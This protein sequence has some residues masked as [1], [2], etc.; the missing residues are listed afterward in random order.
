MGT[1]SKHGSPVEERHEAC[2]VLGVV[3]RSDVDDAVIAESDVDDSG[4]VVR[5]AARSVSRVSEDSA[6]RVVER[7]VGRTCVGGG[8]KR[9]RVDRDDVGGRVGSV[10]SRESGAVDPVDVSVS[11]VD[12]S[13]V[14]VSMSVVSVSTSVVGIFDR[15]DVAVSP[16]VR[17]DEVGEASVGS[18]SGRVVS[19]GVRLVS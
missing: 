16:G 3:D 1:A 17:R 19:R 2:G 13:V 12:A 14:S 18:P 9:L 7:S 8:V 15:D 11:R 4:D 5:D 10:V 6:P